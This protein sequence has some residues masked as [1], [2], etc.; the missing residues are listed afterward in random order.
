MLDKIHKQIKSKH[1]TCL[2]IFDT[3]SSRNITET[4]GCSKGGS[5]SIVYDFAPDVLLGI[6]KIMMGDGV[7]DYVKDFFALPN[8][9][10]HINDV[11]CPSSICA[12]RKEPKN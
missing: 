6:K 9:V 11:A 2:C 1:K 12:R 10:S 7:S 4:M 3:L 5:F 8:F